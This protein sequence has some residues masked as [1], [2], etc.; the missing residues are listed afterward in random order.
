MNVGDLCYLPVQTIII[1]IQI[2][3]N[4]GPTIATVNEINHTV[5]LQ[6]CS[7]HVHVQLE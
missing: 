4:D 3:C 7:I 2:L 1:I 5:Q 6:P